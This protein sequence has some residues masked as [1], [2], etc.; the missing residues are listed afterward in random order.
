MDFMRASGLKGLP[1]SMRSSASKPYIGRYLGT[2][3]SASMISCSISQYW[4]LSSQRRQVESI[5]LPL[6]STIFTSSGFALL[7]SG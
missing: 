1:F 3:G 7:E 2:S 4:M 5:F 6:V